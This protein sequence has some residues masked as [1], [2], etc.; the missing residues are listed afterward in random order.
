VADVRA[1]ELD[2]SALVT[3]I[4]GRELAETR[5]ERSAPHGDSVL[6][7]EGLSGAAVAAFDTDVRAGEIV[8]VTGLLGSGREHVG[9]LVFG[10][11]RRAGGTV[12]V[13]GDVLAGGS[14]FRAVEQ[15]VAFVPADRRGEGAVMTMSVRENMT[16]P[17]LRPLRRFM[18]RLDRRAERRECDRWVGEVGLRPAEPERALDL[19]SGGN[20]QKVVLAKWLRNEPRVLLLDEPTQGV[21]VGA[22]ASIYELVARA[23]DSGAGV[24]ISSSDTRELVVLCNRVLVMRD[25]S[26]VAELDHHELT[27]A[28]LVR[29]SLGLADPA[30]PATHPTE[31]PHV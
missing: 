17:R 13:G 28:R 10:S 15:G 7:V 22:K 18:G 14:P 20:Q 31:V 4:A 3:M 19:F 12:H 5:L 11:I 30:V 16:L 9:G 2:R 25:G 29:E 24:V 6:R 8:G 21:D 23:A 26:V 27:E 1:G